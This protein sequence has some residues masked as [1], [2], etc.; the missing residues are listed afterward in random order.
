MPP[1]AVLL[2]QLRHLAAWYAGMGR[3]S[4]ELEQYSIQP[5]RIAAQIA[6]L[7]VCISI[8]AG[9]AKFVAA[10]GQPGVALPPRPAGVEGFLPISSLVSLKYLIR[11]GVWT[12]IHPAGLVIFLVIVLTGVLLKRSFC[13]WICPVGFASEFLA[14]LGLGAFRKKITLPPVL[15]YPLRSI[16]Y[17]LL[18]FF[19]AAIFGGMSDAALKS[20]IESP[21]NKIADIKM[22]QFFTDISPAALI[23]LAVLAALSFVVPYFWCRY[24]CP[25]G[26]LLGFASL[27]SPVKIRRNEDTCIN[28][29]ACTRVCPAAIMV[30]R[31]EIVESDE[32]HACLKC[33]DACPARNTLSIGTRKN[34]AGIPRLAF[35]ALVVLFFALGT[36]A[37]KLAGYWHTSISPDEYRMHYAAMEGPEYTH[38][39]AMKE[40]NQ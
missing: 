26:A 32:C 34:S 1:T 9:F 12:D 19:L 2:R 35:A 37:P 25:Y 7:A 28:C 38:S 24:L 29:Q 10:L 18:V 21:Y 15:D 6:F 11:T 8:G 16:K 13:S 36:G 5:A 39:A 30:H 31:L 22:M 20:F 23:V 27:F 3:I 4:S 14:R 40:R 33:V 17:L